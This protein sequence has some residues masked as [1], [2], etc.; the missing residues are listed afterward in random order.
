MATAVVAKKKFNKYSFVSS[1]LDAKVLVGGKKKSAN[2]DPSFSIL[3]TTITAI[4]GLGKALNSFN[5]GLI[6]LNTSL[7][8][9]TNK[10]SDIDK[11]AASRNLRSAKLSLQELK[12]DK[13]RSD[14]EKN[15]SRRK[16]DTSTEKTSESKSDDPIGL[17]KETEEK[18]KKPALSFFDGIKN[19]IQ[20]FVKFVVINSVLK[21]MS[22]PK[23]TEKL[24]KTFVGLR[25]IFKF[26]WDVTSAVGGIITGG[27]VNLG[28]GIFDT[29]EGLKKGN[30]GQIFSGFGQLLQAIPG[31]LVLRWV[32]NPMSLVN[33]VMR[34]LSMIGLGDKPPKPEA[35]KPK[36]RKPFAARRVGATRRLLRRR[37]N[38]GVTGIQTRL[39]K[40]GGGIG[41]AFKKGV[42]WLGDKTQKVG[43]KL[44][45]AG[46]FISEQYKRMNKFGDSIKK[47]AVEKL[48]GAGEAIKKKAGEVSEPLVKRAKQI[49]DEKG[50]TKLAQKIGDKAM[51]IIKKLPG[52][53]KIA[54]KIAKEG[55]E[56]MLKKI[57]GKAIPI[58]GGLV[59]LFFA[60]D[61]LSKG[62]KTGAILEAVSGI[63]DIAGVVTGGSTSVASMI[64]DGY[65]FGR[66]FF[67][68]M[69][70]KENAAFDQIM[71]FLNPLKAVQKILPQVPKFEQGGIAGA[72]GKQISPDQV[73]G[74]LL[75]TTSKTLQTLGPGGKLSEQLL[76][77]EISKLENQFG[78]SSVII[79][80]SKLVPPTKK[81]NKELIEGLTQGSDAGIDDLLG[82]NSKPTIS[83]GKVNTSDTTVA[84]LFASI[85]GV[86]ASMV[87]KDFNKGEGGSGGGGGGGTSDGG[88]GDVGDVGEI[89]PGPMHQKGANIAQKLV[90]LL[91]IKDYQAA[92]IVGNI[93]QES[94][95][96]PD[97]VQGS[98]M[99]RGPLKLDGV[100]GYSYPQWTSID[101]QKAFAAYMDRKGFDWRKKGATDEMATG[102]LATEFKGYM[103]SVFKNTKD[104]SAASNWV[105]RN[106]EKP[107]DQGAREAKE[108]ATDSAAVLAKMA[109]GGIMLAKNYLGNNNDP[110]NKIYEKNIGRV[111]GEAIGGVV[112][113]AGGGQ[114]KNG[115]LP[116]S[117]LTPI[118]GGH[119]VRSGDVA[120]SFKQ[121]SDSAKKEGIN[122]VGG[123]TSS[124]RSYEDQVRVAKERPGFAA[125]PGT[126]KH[127]WGIAVDVGYARQQDW[128]HKKGKQFGWI[129]PAWAKSS[130]YEP[131]HFEK[132][133]AATGPTSS[134]PS[135]P[136]SSDS[137]TDS[138][139]QDSS[140]G[141]WMQSLADAF[142]GKTAANLLGTSA[143]STPSSDVPKKA[144][145]GIV[146]LT[147]M[148]QWAQKYPDLAK[149]VKPGQSGYEEIQ[150]YFTNVKFSNISSTGFN[151]AKKGIDLS[152][153]KPAATTSNKNA[154]K[155]ISE[156]PKLPD[157]SVFTKN[158]LLILN[159]FRT[160]V[161]QSSPPQVVM[162][163]PIPQ[164]C[165]SSF[166]S[167]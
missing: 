111:K 38:R 46:D 164:A 58:I 69:I 88:G 106:Y 32:L 148:Q 136:G 133:G 84:G 108:R 156:S 73:G 166:F 151:L 23:N 132:S 37:F 1:K 85:V 57:G 128:M 131:W 43:R 163:S 30:V 26:L 12:Y 71:D 86:L 45:Q 167:N 54:A 110:R 44:G 64:I 140:S 105:L 152:N 18:V 10:F 89:K 75:S 36:P 149:K 27:L 117:A 68:D 79:N 41:D 107:A 159:T 17:K 7:V 119:R 50:I 116:E 20:F 160:N 96:V 5:S 48:K 129:N 78:K 33:D 2:T 154:N 95:L 134:G 63:L 125:Q 101:R 104:V 120:D 22:D 98:G 13:K 87:N 91:G 15:R 114:Y 61:R 112:K 146:N 126:S 90:S 59:N 158:K 162:S 70:K 123:L 34:I 65:L 4:N 118:G 155:V 21:W 94:A 40:I 135:G 142:S 35:P 130:P 115:Q 100:T 49:L 145:G 9:V 97:R 25:K 77:G 138:N 92:G 67:P 139:Q 122:L 161:V 113:F 83:D 144:G 127:G 102:F 24:G 60:Y 8:K 55:G 157:E 103:S 93:I 52:Y 42:G 16:L 3:K 80:Q 74:A 47:G 137:K 141:N 99:K 11:K 62:D 121:M 153:L 39:N 53:N 51:S 14:D 150:A 76:G 72:N 81:P 124:Y 66:D 109:A 6:D 82:K 28:S 165:Y 31:L 29:V 19:F 56:G 147:P 143:P